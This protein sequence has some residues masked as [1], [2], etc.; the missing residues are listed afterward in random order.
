MKLLKAPEPDSP[1]F[2]LMR[3]KVPSHCWFLYGENGEVIKEH[4]GPL[5]V[6]DILF[7]IKRDSNEPRRV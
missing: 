5:K 6:R 1:E 7:F 3:V 2:V 4:I